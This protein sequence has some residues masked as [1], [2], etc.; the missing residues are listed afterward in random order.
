VRKRQSALENQVKLFRKARWFRKNRP[1]AKLKELC[2]PK[3]GRVSSKRQ[4]FFVFSSIFLRGLHAQAATCEHPPSRL[5]H[6]E[7]RD[8]LFAWIADACDRIEELCTMTSP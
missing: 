7:E 6:I 4:D 2:F 1:F 3:R 5:A 8:D